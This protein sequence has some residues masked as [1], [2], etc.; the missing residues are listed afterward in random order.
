MSDHSHRTFSSSDRTSR[1]RTQEYR[2]N[3]PS[4][5]SNSRYGDR[6]RN[7]QREQFRQPP[8]TASNQYRPPLRRSPRERS[9]SQRSG[10]ELPAHLRR[11]QH[12][13]HEDRSDHHSPG[14]NN[15]APTPPSTFQATSTYYDQ[16][17]VFGLNFP[18]FVQPTAWSRSKHIQGL[19]ISQVPLVPLLYQQWDNQCLRGLAHG[20]FTG[21]VTCRSIKEV[22][23]CTHLLSMIR[24]DNI[25]LDIMAE[26]INQQK[27][28][29]QQQKADA[30]K[31]L[32]ENIF[33]AMKGLIPDDQSAMFEKLRQLEQ[34]NMRLKQSQ[35]TEKFPP[36]PPGFT[37][38][39][40][41]DARG[42]SQRSSA[43]SR[44][45]NEA[46]P[47]LNVSPLQNLF[48]RQSD[49]NRRHTNSR[50]PRRPRFE[51]PQRTQRAPRQYTDGVARAPIDVMDS[52]RN[53]RLHEMVDTPSTFEVAAVPNAMTDCGEELEGTT[54]K[55]VD[56]W[57][58]KF[59]LTEEQRDKFYKMVS[60]AQA[61]YDNLIQD[62]M[63][64]TRLITQWGMSAT[65]ALEMKP[66][67]MINIMTMLAIVSE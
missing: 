65:S 59:Q 15:F 31:K 55:D 20:F 39:S 8:S 5:Q 23:F 54:P 38:R 27:A 53:E 1:A 46:T 49:N 52:P 17:E 6:G 56:K 42:T 25:D 62:Q 50:S 33:T 7:Q 45:S 43:N 14:D 11:Q 35:T 58:K 48:S 60:K 2:N 44:N 67:D 32:A 64:L 29:S 12:G 28:Y 40:N 57:M 18:R 66:D 9:R 21:I 30:V 37:G 26:I 16:R 51:T 24:S 22:V 41:D 63:Y 13:Y 4:S 36:V 10:R 3:V 61:E 34:E 19:D 47:S